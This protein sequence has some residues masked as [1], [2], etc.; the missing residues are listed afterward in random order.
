MRET[1]TDGIVGQRR[2]PQPLHRAADSSLLHHPPLYQ[3]A[4]LTRIAAVDDFF[5]L[6]DESLYHMELPAVTVVVNQL[7]AE[8]GRY[9][10]QRA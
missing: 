5:G 4:L 10:R 3:F 6:S 7:Y 2:N 8:S 1:L 9:H